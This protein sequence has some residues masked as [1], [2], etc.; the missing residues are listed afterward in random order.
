MYAFNA[1][2]FIV[3]RMWMVKKIVVRRSHTFVLW[4][5]EAKCTVKLITV[6]SIHER[7]IVRNG[8]LILYEGF[9]V[10]STWHIILP[11]SFSLYLKCKKN[12]MLAFI[13]VWICKSN[14]AK[15]YFFHCCITNPIFNI[16]V[17]QIYSVVRHFTSYYYNMMIKISSEK[18]NSER[19]FTL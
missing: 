14:I 4:H 18:P 13:H 19:T 2:D 6:I 17:F 8:F 16:H 11:S 1:S 12:M 9:H 5:Q 7:T 3:F 10:T 15:I